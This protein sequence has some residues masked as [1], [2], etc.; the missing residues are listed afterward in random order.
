[1]RR[2]RG[3]DAAGCLQDA[4][5]GRCF[6][7][8]KFLQTQFFL[9]ILSIDLR[10]SG[11]NQGLREFAALVGCV[12]GLPCGML[13]GMKRSRRSFAP[14]VTTKASDLQVF[15]GSDGT[16]T[17]DLRRDRPILVIPGWAGI[18]GD[19]RREQDFSTPGLRVF[20]GTCGSFRRPP[21]GYARDG[22]LPDV[23]TRAA[24]RSAFQAL[25]WVSKLRFLLAEPRRRLARS[26]TFVA[27]SRL[28]RAVRDPERGRHLWRGRVRPRRDGGR[29]RAR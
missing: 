25:I 20:A 6:P 15:Y 26:H 8:R 4:R 16:R 3:V 23:A 22:V 18:G 12:R 7:R 28:R 29:P 19:F 21:A 2:C 1:M 9:P 14:K 17:R 11:R 5:L 27:A 24:H 13:R 10:L